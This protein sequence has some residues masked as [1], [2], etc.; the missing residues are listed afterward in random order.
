[1]VAQDEPPP[2]NGARCDRQTVSETVEETSV[3][4]SATVKKP[5]R[6]QGLA[7]WL[8]GLI[9]VGLLV[10]AVLHFG[11]LT[12][13][14]IML[15]GAQ[16][17]WLLAALALQ[18]ST[19]VSL[20][21]GW[22]VVLREAKAPRPLRRLLPI[23]ITKLFADQIIPAAGMGGDVLLIDR[24]IALGVPRGAAVAVLLVS[25]IAFYA[26]YAILAVI[27]L[28]LLWLAGK[29]SPWLVVFVAVFLA[30]SLAIPG[31]ALWLRR[32]GSHP[33]SPLADRIPIVRGLLHIVGEAPAALISNQ[34]LIA[35]VAALNGL[36]FIADA[37]TLLVCFRALGAHV[38]YETA[39][40]AVIAAS[41][42][43]T[44]GPIPL[45]LGSFELGSTGMLSLLGVPL[46]AAFAAT[47]LLRSFTL[48]LPLLPG[49]VLM[50]GVLRSRA[51][52]GHPHSDHRT[53]RPLEIT[54]VAGSKR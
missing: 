48:W 1:M 9:A 34:R 8:I 23:A 50:R 38:P 6:F 35:S 3:S 7:G 46:E 28:A 31:F 13:F 43:V 54:K 4:R 27:M 37:A 24:L 25:M 52:K 22:S 16:P 2:P 36:I 10:F 17:G 15:R 51:G 39:F 45:G 40:I 26:V 21:L 19:Y 14:A 29:A 33:L 47:L 11:D 5:S 53:P 41:M 20:A 18:A 42:V 30:V 32:R 49:L 12:A 44:L